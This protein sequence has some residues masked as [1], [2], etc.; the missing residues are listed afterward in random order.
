M[1]HSDTESAALPFGATKRPSKSQRARRRK[2]VRAWHHGY[3]Y[4]ASCALAAARPPPGLGVLSRGVEVCMSDEMTCQEFLDVVKVVRRGTPARTDAQWSCRYTSIFACTSRDFSSTEPLGIEVDSM[5]RVS[6]V[7]PGSPAATRSIMRG[8]WLTA[9][10]MDEWQ[11]R[12]SHRNSPEAGETLVR[13]TFLHL[14]KVTKEVI[15][16]QDDETES[17][18]LLMLTP[19]FPRCAKCGRDGR[20]SFFGRCAFCCL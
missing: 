11:R 3:R 8:W 16:W 20:T 4:A 5:L 13:L 9:A 14:E 7:L 19:G 17:G 15:G 1:A 12:F 10:S 2:C 18:P 6:R